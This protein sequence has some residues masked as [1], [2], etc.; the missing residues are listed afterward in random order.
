MEGDQKWVV[1]SWL[2]CCPA[3]YEFLRDVCLPYELTVIK[4][5]WRG[6]A[7]HSHIFFEIWRNRMER[8]HDKIV[9][10]PILVCLFEK[11]PH[12]ALRVRKNVKDM[13]HEN[14]RRSPMWVPKSW[15]LEK[16]RWD[17]LQSYQKEEAYFGDFKRAS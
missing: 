7:K 16:K 10:V 5:D 12:L 9:L 3:I 4:L 1:T 15:D 11:E 14:A 17:G 13:I 8:L 2:K 6:H